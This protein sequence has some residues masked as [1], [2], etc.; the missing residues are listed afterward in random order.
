MIPFVQTMK[1]SSGPVKVAALENTRNFQ[2]D[3]GGR[4]K[5]PRPVSVGFQQLCVPIGQRKRGRCSYGSL[6]RENPGGVTRLDFKDGAVFNS[7]C[8]AR[9]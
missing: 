2:C 9:P 1:P 3:G 7:R 5:Q 6:K 4:Q 8:V